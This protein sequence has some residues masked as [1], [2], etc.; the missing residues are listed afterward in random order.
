VPQ[1]E[2]DSLRVV[3]KSVA[4]TT[5]IG[6]GLMNVCRGVSFI[7]PSGALVRHV[8]FFV[9]WTLFFENVVQ[10]TRFSIEESSFFG[11]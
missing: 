10:M 1:F 2:E 9:V 11:F 8:R 3:G 6:S 4:K 7:K 5:W